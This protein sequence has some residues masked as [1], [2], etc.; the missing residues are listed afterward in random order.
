MFLVGGSILVHGVPAFGHAVQAWSEGIGG[1]GGTL[2]SMVV[3]AAVGIVAG[4]VVLG[5]VEAVK[6]L[7][8]SKT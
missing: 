3:D 7:R 5:A 8:G 4:A 1:I 2:A 6:K